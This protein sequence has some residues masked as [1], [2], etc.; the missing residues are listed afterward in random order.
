[1]GGKKVGVED[2]WPCPDV[3]DKAL[4]KHRMG[5]D[6]TGGH[7][8]GSGMSSASPASYY[9][10]NSVLSVPLLNPRTTV[11]PAANIYSPNLS[12]DSNI[13]IF[14]LSALQQHVKI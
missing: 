8:Q 2:R 1:M 11:L 7:Q 5:R 10:S 13:F 14:D 6:C 3:K 9:F 4:P 12:T